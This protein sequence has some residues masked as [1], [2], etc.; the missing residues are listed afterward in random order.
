MS[1][2]ILNLQVREDI[3][4]KRREKLHGL[5]VFPVA[6]SA[7]M[8]GNGLGIYWVRPQFANEGN[9]FSHTGEGPKAG[10][11]RRFKHRSAW[12]LNPRA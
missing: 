12:L 11:P 1:F 9:E 3:T 4:S 8:I 6:Q 10:R 5:E 2:F 7:G